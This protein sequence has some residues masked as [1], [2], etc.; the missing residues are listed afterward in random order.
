[1]AEDLLTSLRSGRLLADGGIGTSLVERGVAVDACFEVLNADDP[2][3]VA[4][5]HRSFVEAGAE[6]VTSNTFGANRF[7]L[8]ARGQGERVSELNRLGVDIA[9]ALGVPVTGSVG[10]LGVRIAPLGRVRR[11]EVFDAYVE[12]MSALVDAGVDALQVETQSDLAEVEEAIA[13]ARKVCDLPLI[14]TATFTRDDRTLLGSTPRQVALR[15]AELGVDALGVNCGEGPAQALRIA[16]EMRAAAG[17]IPLVARPNA[18]G[19][20]QVGGRFL[21]PATPEYFGWMA[22]ELRSAGVALVGGCCGTGAEHIRAMAASVREADERVSFTTPSDDGRVHDVGRTGS[23]DR[24]SPT[25]LARVL[26]E[27][28]FA[29]GVEVEPPRSHSTARMIQAA[30]TLRD[31]GADVIDVTDSPMARLRMSPWAACRLIA[32]RTGIETVLH[33]PT[34]GR[35]LL[36]LQGDLLAVHALGIRNVFVCL[37]DPVTVGDYPG[38]TDHVDVAPSGLLTLITSGFNAGRDHSGASIGEPTAFV[39]GCALNPAP[40]D[41]SKECQL[42][43]RKVEAG[44]T[45]ALSQP[46]YSLDPV[47]RFRTAYEDLYGPLEL[48]ILAGVLPLASSRHAEFLHNEVPGMVI[49]DAVREHLRSASGS[50]EAEG[51]TMAVDLVREL[52]TEVAGIYLMPQFGR[53]DI[54]ADIVE[55]AAG[56]RDA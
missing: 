17:S 37:G 19:P 20:E 25:S 16:R 55:A 36:R 52:R 14:V 9:C 41:L 28:R 39:A 10:P 53:Y 29:I 30:Q 32:E 48:P 1:M 23:G 21:Y 5:V 46:V 33:F 49:P 31:A 2:E 12:Q 27:G 43:H 35:N 38:G 26:D 54:A 50:E 40:G 6:V 24:E 18:G 11:E 22:Q 8:G 47:R 4:G 56:A 7:K 51:V 3:L 42:L 15:L 45:F 44:A 13:A 34:R